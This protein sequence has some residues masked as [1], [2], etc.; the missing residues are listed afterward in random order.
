MMRQGIPFAAVLIMLGNAVQAQS[1]PAAK[2]LMDQANYWFAQ[3]KPQDAEHA[4]DRLL[5]LD[6]DNSDALALLAQLESQQGDRSHAEA[7]LAHLRAVQPN[8]PRIATVEQAIRAGNID[9]AGLAEA[10]RLASDGRNVEAVTRYQQLFRGATPPAMLAVEYYDTLSGT[11]GGWDAARAGLARVV[12]VAPG[13]MRAQL[14]YAQL[15][16]YR[17]KTRSEGAQ[18]LALLAHAQETAAA[19]AK[20]WRQ[21]LEWMPVDTSS[22]QAYEAWL[23]DHPNDGDIGRRLEQARNPPS[24]PIDEAAV[25]RKAGFTALDA[26]RLQDAETAFQ[27]VLAKTP[28]DADALGG[29]GLVRLKQGN[30]AEARTL[31]ARAIAADPAHK[32]RWMGALQGASVGQDFA[33]ARTMM[34]RGQFDAAE[35][36]LHAIIASGG[37]TTGAQL[38]LADLLTRRGDLSGAETQYRAVLAHQPNN[39]DALVG[40]AQVLNRQGR[41]TDAEAMLDRAQSAGNGR[42]VGRIR[43]DALRQQAATA[44]D[45][46]AKE[47]LLRAAV[48]ADPGDPWTRLD[49]ARVQLAS[50]RK[51]EAR[52]IMAEV[53]G[54]TNPGADALRAGAMF[55]VE[56]ARPADA[57]ALVNRLPAAARTADMRALLAQATRQNDIRGAISLAAVSPAA[58][59]EKLLTLAAQPDPD[60]ANGVAV[61]RAFLQM[62][63]PAAAREA[64]AT[65]QAATRTPTPA[66][67]IAYAGLLLQAGDER[68]AKIL[69]QALTET[70]GLTPD[71]TSAL[72][73]LRAG[74][75]IR[76]A[77]TL[78]GQHQQAAAYDVLAPALARQPDNP[79][80][81]LAVARLYAAA[82]QP[83]KAL[84]INQAVLEREPSNLDA[85]K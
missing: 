18:R 84:A 14:A 63:N 8:D 34:Q 51:T 26:G 47:A 44:A 73:R 57:A 83:R 66:Q 39:A 42:A 22:I 59:R 29:L 24:A 65:A 77:D 11:E 61:G 27:T 20:P 54:G 78:N 69:L 70:S 35:R 67:R 21:A 74:S 28:E 10:R 33:A 9:P 71:Q 37:D 32:A 16:T 1:N 60:G 82:D 40:A 2:V 68:G 5:R 58:A 23:V 80:L 53:T 17:D 13:D 81:N 31:L 7:T 79:E 3:N 15:L 30:A 52:Q 48:S 19:A 25:K 75:A 64:L 62:G 56:D 6:P 76:E 85:R 12:G 55:A 43:A 4:L 36:Q 50:G 45:P 72:N 46:G 49:L 38:M 41:G